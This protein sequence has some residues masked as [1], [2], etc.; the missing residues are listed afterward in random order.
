MCHIAADRDL[1]A[2]AQSDFY[3]LGYPSKDR[4]VVRQ[5]KV[6]DVF[7]RSVHA[8][9]ELNKIVCSNREEVR[10]FGQPT[11]GLTTSNEP[12]ELSD[13]AL[14]A[15]TMSVFTDRLGHQYGQG[16]SVQPDEATADF[17]QA[18]NAAVE[19]LLAHP[20]CTG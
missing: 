4:W 18:E 10:F 6:F 11:A 15:L 9:Q 19:W 13:G 5:V 20:A 7:V 16:V 12:V 1:F 3:N 17:T 14:I 2:L 8:K